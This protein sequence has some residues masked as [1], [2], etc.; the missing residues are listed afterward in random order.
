MHPIL[1]EIPMPWG[2]L[3]VY[4]YGVMLGTS[5]IFAWYFIHGVVG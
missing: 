2:T 3:P 1:V 4:S 5:L